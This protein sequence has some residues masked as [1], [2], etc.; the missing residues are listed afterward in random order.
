MYRLQWQLRIDSQ[1]ISLKSS[2]FFN[3]LIFYEKDYRRFI[4]SFERKLLKQKRKKNQNA[5][6]KKKILKSLSVMNNFLE[7]KICGESR[8]VRGQLY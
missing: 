6:K 2:I 8:G 3:L 1:G 5:K 7:K 4:L